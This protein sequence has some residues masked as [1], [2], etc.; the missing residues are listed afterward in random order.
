M[1]TTSNNQATDDNWTYS[2]A[3]FAGTFFFDVRANDAL[4]KPL[5]SIDNG[6]VADLNAADLA[7]SAAASNDRSALG[8]TI[9]I[10]SDGRI[11]YSADSIQS[12][13]NQLAAGETLVDSFLYAMK[14]GSTIVWATA[15]ITI[16]GTND[17]PIARADTGL[18]LEDA[19]TTGTVAFNDSDVDHGAAL[20][21]T[22]V[23]QPP[24]GFAMAPDGSWAFDGSDPAYRS[25]P[26]GFQ[27]SQ[28]VQ[29]RVT[30]EHGASSSSYLT[31]T[32]IGTNDAPVVTGAVT[33]A[34][35][36]DGAVSAL[37]ALANA[38]DVDADTVL[39]V[40]GVP[41]ELPPGVSFDAATRSFTLDPS[42]ATYQSLAQGATTTVSVS[43]GV[44]DGKAT[45][46]ATVSWTITG[47][48]DAPVVTGAVTGAAIEGGG[49]VS[50]NA[51]A[52]ASDADAGT[53]LS[54][55]DVPAE[56]PAGVSYDQATGGFTLDPTHA[57][58]Q[59]LSQGATTMVS[60]SYGVSDGIATTLASVSW[61]VT[62]TNDGPVAVAA[63][64]AV[65]EDQT[66]SGMLVATDVD[67]DSS[68]VF[69]PS[70]GAPDGFTLNADGS[71]TFDANLYEYQS[72][73]EGESRDVAIDYVVTDDQGATSV[74]T[75]TVTVTGANDAPVTTSQWA[76]ATEGETATG[77]L[78]A[79]DQDNGAELSFAVGDDAPAGFILNPDG[80][81]TFDGAN[82][83]Y[84]GLT[85]GEVRLIRVPFSVTDEHGAATSSFMII[86][87]TGTNDTPALTG[88]PANLPAGAEDT[89]YVVTQEQLLAGWSDPEGTALQ[90]T[91][92]VATNAT[93]VANADG[94][95]T[96]TP[97]ANFNGVVDFKWE[98]TDGSSVAVGTA[99]LIIAPVNDAA[100]IG[101]TRTGSV[102]ETG[103]GS[104]GI[105][106]ATG[107]LTI[108]D[109]DSP[110]EFH[111]VSNQQSL[112]GFGFVTLTSSGS[113]SYNL[114]NSAL[115]TQRLAAGETVA[116]SFWAT[117][118]DGT[119]SLITI[120]ITG[121]ND[122]PVV[123]P[124]KPA[125]PS[126]VEDT[127]YILTPAQL[128]EGWSDPEGDPLVVRWISAGGTTTSNADGSW[129]IRP[130]VNHS[131]PLLI[132]YSIGDGSAAQSHSIYLNFA[133]V[134]DPATFS[135]TLSGS[136]R[137]DA[138][139]GSIIGDAN[140]SDV[141]NPYDLWRASDWQVS[142]NGWGSYRV[143]DRG[144]W[145]YRAD[146]SLAAVN[147]LNAGQQLADSITLVSADGTV[148]NMDVT[149]VGRTD[150]TYATPTV[151]TAPDSSDFDTQGGTPAASAV[152]LQGTSGN[153]F[154]VKGSN[155]A[156][157]ISLEAG[158][159][160]S[161][162]GFGG[163]DLLYGDFR[164]LTAPGDQ[165]GRNSIYGGA[166]NDTIHGGA[167]EDVIYGGS[168]ADVIFGNSSSTTELKQNRL[169]GGSGNDTIHAGQYGD[170][171][172]GGTG[173]DL[174]YSGAGADAFVFM[175]PEDTGD[176][177]VGYQQGIDMLDF[178]AF[179]S[180]HGSSQFVGK[181][182]SPE[183]LDPG[184]IGFMHVNGNTVV[185]FDAP[186]TAPG[187]D[188]EVTLI[189]QI[190]LVQRDMI[191]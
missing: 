80:S 13:A 43:Y 87:L 3:A 143:T 1:A 105:A 58:Y 60:V 128:L 77:T 114:D 90:A 50:L 153:D 136:I 97:A 71:W 16:T 182:S 158:S 96:L 108:S 177:I 118:E 146:N 28:L 73:A 138:F 57:A 166:G 88:Q 7:R 142:T 155:F 61:I 124:A 70:S 78:L 6:Q 135:G 140:C 5:H 154:Q 134:N 64:S 129:S 122:A 31:L 172:D 67:A 76:E 12:V 168:G 189:G 180:T 145:E 107:Q 157:I 45:I 186:G 89:A 167:G 125:L 148:R 116:D 41:A 82:A 2:E 191:V 48:N 52:N 51:L 17:T 46:A 184:Q 54:I 36:E 79:F 185:Y 49:S 119:Q 33:G 151:S 59:S 150:W 152:D 23:G 170:Q 47:T 160:D 22:V 187:I 115:V 183:L 19:V 190:E 178:W 68:L 66:V 34:A 174:I 120:A 127:I 38:S 123:S 30:D 175:A 104:A 112:G 93:V 141:D 102:T 53:I 117:A 179:R 29:Y 159:L 188:F 176:T 173:A 144:V 55:V 35:S 161:M 65:I 63:T 100:L 74:S 109:N 42:H 131:G 21:Y 121:S 85:N 156:D 130:P 86:A 84:D 44:S 15:R 20:Q 10:T 39:A 24:A 91:N 101:G 92:M 181:V 149:I 111:A 132:S 103:F 106:S 72:L 32:I 139:S 83:A 163:D 94:S 18:G 75:L 98:V 133:A 169:Y 164:D 11:G 165:A 56:L 26:E 9:W 171:I 14:Q 137:E 4:K 99:Q 37:N 81:W 113:W 162:Y 40:V 8:A 62:G 147:N 27:T 110:A 126:G 69:E 95:F 25:L